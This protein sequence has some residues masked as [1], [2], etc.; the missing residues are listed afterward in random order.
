[1]DIGSF[2]DLH[3]H[4]RGYCPLPILTDAYDFSPIYLRMMLSRSL[5]KKSR[6]LLNFYYHRLR[7]IFDTYAEN[8]GKH[9]DD[10]TM[11]KQYFILM[12]SRVPCAY[13]CDLTQMSYI[14]ELRSAETVH[15][16]LRSI[17]SCF[18]K[19]VIEH[20]DS[21]RIGKGIHMREEDSLDIGLANPSEKRALQTIFTPDG[22]RL[23]ELP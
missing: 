17:V 18:Y 11:L 22:K 19:Y 8:L 4:R 14:I 15:F 1:M 12:G 16:S 23:E 13:I 9:P 10:L 21:S 6:N 3:R 5:V 20:T 2:R 7:S